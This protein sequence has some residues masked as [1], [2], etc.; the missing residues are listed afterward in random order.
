VPRVTIPP[1]AERLVVR[2]YMPFASLLLTWF[3]FGLAIGHADVV[4]LIAANTLVLG[5][6]ALCTLELTRVLARRSAAP[7]A[8]WTSSRRTALRIDAL[9]LVA[10]LLVAAA[11]VVLLAARGMPEAAGMAAIIALGIPARHPLGLLVARRN[12]EVTWRAGVAAAGIV[13][14]AIVFGF[15]LPWQAA[16][17]V[18]ALRDWV[19]LA[20]TA[21]LAPRHRPVR[22][23]A[24]PLTFAE[25]AGLTEANARRRLSYRLMKT[26]F[27]VALG[28]LGNFAARTGRGA[29]RFDSKLSRLVPRHRA[30][31]A[32]FTAGCGTIA[33]VL[34]LAT[35]EPLAFLVAAAFWRLGALGGSALLWWKYKAA[36]DDDDDDDD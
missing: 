28:P 20:A 8:V 13:G 17:L 4:R 31:F 15:G 27:A 19:G 12:R 2:E 26:L 36:A 34:L 6:R 33:L 35:R 3:L 14:A 1:L 7:D 21:L 29:G 9:A 22:E 18:I 32:L 16:A 25:A 10:C 24:E 30:G 23:S 5:V 11:L